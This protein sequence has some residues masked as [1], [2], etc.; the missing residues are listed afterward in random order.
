MVTGPF[1]PTVGTKLVEP[2]LHAVPNVAGLGA[3]EFDLGLL[4]LLCHY[5]I[6]IGSM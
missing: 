3:W 2:N 6:V 5:K 4:Q 1:L